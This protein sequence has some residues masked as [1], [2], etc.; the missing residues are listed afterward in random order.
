MDRD[1][2]GRQE[3]I[4]DA[5]VATIAARSEEGPWRISADEICGHF[6]E[7]DYY[8]AAYAARL[9]GVASFD[10]ENVGELVRVL[11]KLLGPGSADRLHSAGLFLTLDER[12][13]LTERL[14][15]SVRVAATIHVPERDTFESMLRVLKRYD[16]AL[17]TYLET[18]LSLDSICDRCAAD[19]VAVRSHRLDDDDRVSR[20]LLGTV[21]RY[22]QTLTRRRVVSIESLAPAL[23][24]YLAAIAREA[25]YLPH[26][27]DPAA[28]SETASRDSRTWAFEAL[29][30]SRNATA[31]EIQLR[32][33]ELMRTYHPDIN[34][35]GLEMSKKINAA[36]GVLTE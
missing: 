28:A 33:R 32:Y 22:L 12:L 31:R 17:A 29:G 5:I 2:T 30:L 7:L 8:R 11:D 15:R 23:I 26:R 27:E 9:H 35:D 25:G 19:Y 20:L 6:G 1:M 4:L 18:Y 3:A 13:D 14:V 16:R 10:D 21:R 36:Y 34:P 24:E